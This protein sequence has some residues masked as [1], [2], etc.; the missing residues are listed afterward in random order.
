VGHH[1]AH[2]HDEAS[3]GEE[4]G[5]PAGVGGRGNQDFARFQAS[6][7]GVEDDSCR[8]CDASG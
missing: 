4:E 2:F 5:G 3:G 8:G 1:A 6:A 7:R